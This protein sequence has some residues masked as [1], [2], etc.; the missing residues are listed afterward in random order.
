MEIRWC[1]ILLG[2]KT[3]SQACKLKSKA[4]LCV[5]HF[6]YLCR[7]NRVFFRPYLIF[8]CRLQFRFQAHNHYRYDV[9]LHSQNDKGHI[10]LDIPPG[11]MVYCDLEEINLESW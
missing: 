7:L 10:P 1:L 6:V 8:S 9:P 11:G 3:D 5:Y 4:I 2:K